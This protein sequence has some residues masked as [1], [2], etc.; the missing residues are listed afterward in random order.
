[1][2]TVSR[3]EHLVSAGGVVCRPAG[4]E[5]EIAICGRRSP[6]GWTWALP[7]GTPNPRETVEETALREVT[8]ETGLEVT[9]ET[10]INSIGY[11]F[12]RATDG[13]RCHKTVHFYLMSAV[14]GSTSQHDQEFDMVRW[15]PSEEALQT[16]TYKNEVDILKKALKMVE[17][18]SQKGGRD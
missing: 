8:E 4:D 6:E 14:G 9:L 5:V 1:M 18:R 11:W 12:V 15:S 13:V 17:T 7:K 16:L 3:V 2:A 10:P